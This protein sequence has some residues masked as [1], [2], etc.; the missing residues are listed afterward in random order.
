MIEI[1]IS[2]WRSMKNKEDAMQK[3]KMFLN[4]HSHFEEHYK[5]TGKYRLNKDNKY[6]KS[7]IFQFESRNRISYRLNHKLMNRLTKM[8]NKSDHI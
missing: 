6:V 3:V 8:S 5:W 1:E 7:T 4:M 2:H